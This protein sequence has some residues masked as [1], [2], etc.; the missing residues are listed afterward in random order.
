M[1]RGKSSH[2]KPGPYTLCRDKEGVDDVWH[3]YAA[4]DEHPFA[5]LPYWGDDEGWTARA[6]AT[7]R[8]LAAAPELLRALE[9]ADSCLDL[10]AGS[11]YQTSAICGE[12]RAVISSVLEPNYRPEGES[13]QDLQLYWGRCTECHGS[14]GYLNIGR[15]HWFYCEA[16]RVKW[17]AGENLFS[18]WRS[19]TD[20]DW[21]R[22]DAFLH[23]FQE[24]KPE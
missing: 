4:G 23:E 22:N 20:A 24:I 8:L 3:I 16:H 13:I 7:A 6:A 1:G 11:K 21:K 10:V 18:S 14:D 12:V 15:N 9:L 17:C 2:F 5:S 19:E